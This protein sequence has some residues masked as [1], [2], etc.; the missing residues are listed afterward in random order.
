M[1]EILKT[2]TTVVHLS[3]NKCKISSDNPDFLTIKTLL[4]RNILLSRQE[5][6]SDE[7]KKIDV[8]RLE[9]HDLK[10]IAEKYRSET[11]DF[12]EKKLDDTHIPQIICIFQYLNLITILTLSKNNLNNDAMQELSNLLRMNSTLTRLNLAYNQIATDGAIEIFNAIEHHTQLSTLDLSHNLIHIENASEFKK[13]EKIL[14]EHQESKNTPVKRLKI[15]VSQ[16]YFAKECTT[17]LSRHTFFYSQDFYTNDNGEIK[18]Q[19]LISF[20]LIKPDEKIDY[21][22]HLIFILRKNSQHSNDPEHAMIVIE[23]VN[24]NS[25]KYIHMYDFRPDNSDGS[26]GQIQD[27]PFLPDRTASEVNGYE[28]FYRSTKR[29]RVEELKRNI[30]RDKIKKLYYKKLPTGKRQCSPDKHTYNCL[31]W[32]IAKVNEI[33]PPRQE[34]MKEPTF[35]PIPSLYLRGKRAVQARDVAEEKTK[36]KNSET[37]F[38]SFSH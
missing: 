34:K 30:E 9:E 36:N 14:Q 17:L 7:L 25:Q 27:K 38:S 2:N 6:N 37:T 23:G 8:L 26:L 1:L 33:I 10:H 32:A 19:K 3:F 16:N 15:D 35:L 29:V 28:Y 13:M 31:T 11:L 20:S 5:I 12:S 24:Q 21:D 22:N 4:Q 18:K